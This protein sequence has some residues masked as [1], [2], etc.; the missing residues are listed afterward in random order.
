MGKIVSIT[1]ALRAVGEIPGNLSQN[2]E[3]KVS[4]FYLT[5]LKP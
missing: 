1:L 4:P 2:M 3:K 5:F